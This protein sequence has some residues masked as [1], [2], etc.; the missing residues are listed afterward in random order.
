MPIDT[1]IAPP[2]QQS[3]PPQD[4]AVSAAPAVT[5]PAP[6]VRQE[7]TPAQDFDNAQDAPS[8]LAVATK[9]I[10]TPVA[11][12]AIKA[13]DLFLQGEKTFNN[14]VAPV[15]KAGGLAT[16]EGRVAAAKQ[17]SYFKQEDPRFFDAFI[18]YLSG[19]K[20]MAKKMITGGKTETVTVPD[21][22]GEQIFV[23]KNALG[24]V[25][26]AEDVLGN[27][28][29]KEEFQNRYVG[30]QTY[31]NLLSY[32]G[33]ELIQ[34][35]NIEK[36]Q[37]SKAVNNAW[38]AATPDLNSKYSSIFD[39]A[40][41]LRGKEMQSAEFAEALRF[42]DFALGNID[43]VSKGRN[44][45]SQAQINNAKKNG[46][47]LTKEE[48]A[49]VKGSS[50]LGKLG[51]L[52]WTTKG[53]ENK[54]TGKTLSFDELMNDQT[55]HDVKNE[56]NKNYKQTQQN[57]FESD[58]FSRLDKQD[59]DRLRRIVNNSYSVA[60]KQAELQEKH[61]TPAFMILPTSFEMKDSYTAA[62]VKSLQGIFNAKAMELYNNYQEKFIAR[63]RGI[64]PDPGEIEAGFVQ[65][66]EYKRLLSEAKKASNDL[67]ERPSAR[68]DVS[69]PES[70]T[71]PAA[72]VPKAPPK[73]P[74]RA[75]TNTVTGRPLGG[76][77][78][79][80]VGNNSGGRQPS[81]DSL[82]RA[83]GGQ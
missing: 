74:A 78:G 57:L 53:I 26:D 6:A 49:Q 14:M 45:L 10:G 81:L 15:E 21:I 52:I 4:A 19:D 2:S 31:E 9:H 77:G 8:M 41:A 3:M 22:N 13:A 64:A 56:I 43:A 48:M 70:E 51:E 71:R 72:N 7:T 82:Y 29:S 11:V 69:Y 65:T 38:N 61:G 50:L 76:A 40:E 68:I 1:A 25:V 5:A 12:A 55:T 24:K 75:N 67:I 59:Q 54:S 16:P 17:A 20:G 83:A 73:P 30:R 35:D 36:L 80:A 34:K 58:K 62:Q 18:Y 32:K 37:K 33:Q 47:Q 60:I 46:E 44:V 66:P 79:A 23:T 63:S 42:S 39:D 28:L 27:K